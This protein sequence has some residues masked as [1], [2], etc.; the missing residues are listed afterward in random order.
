ML[1]HSRKLLLDL[2]KYANSLSSSQFEKKS[3]T[4]NIVTQPNPPKWKI[5]HTVADRIGGL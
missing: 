4:D 5:E 3:A 1:K 2:P